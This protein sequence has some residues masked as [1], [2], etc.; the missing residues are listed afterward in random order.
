MLRGS[1]DDDIVV[2][3]LASG[4]VLMVLGAMVPFWRRRTATPVSGGPAR[5]S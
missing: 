1:P 2:P 3:T 5:L 4:M